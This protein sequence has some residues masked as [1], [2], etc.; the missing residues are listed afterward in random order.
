MPRIA[1]VRKFLRFRPRFSVIRTLVLRWRLLEKE[2]PFGVPKWRLE[3]GDWRLESA[4]LLTVSCLLSPVSFV[5]ASTTIGTNISTGGTLT[6]TGASTL[7]GGAT[8]SD[9]TLL[10]LSAIQNTAG[11]NE[12]LKLPQ[13]SSAL[14]AP[15]S[16]EGFLAWRADTNELQVYDGSSWTTL[17]S[18]GGGGGTTFSGSISPTRPS[19]WERRGRCGGSPA[20]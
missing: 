3:I 12:G 7:Q 10:D 11:T 14:G 15:S 17:S 13:K 19:C 6:V 16:G 5:L 4:I 1:A 2:V 20:A 18:G 9:D 8:L